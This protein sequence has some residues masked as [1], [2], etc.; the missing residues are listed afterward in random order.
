MLK[1][2]LVAV[3]ATCMSMA[4]MANNTIVEMKTSMGNIEIE[5]FNDKAPIS[6]KNF[7]DYTKAKFYNGTIFHRV[8]P[9]FMV[10]GGGMT[11]DLV[12]KP[13]RPAIQNE[14]SNGLSNKRGTLAMARTNLPHSATSQFFINVVDNNF[15]DRS[16]NNAGYAVFGQV[17]KGMHVLSLPPAFNLSHDQTLQ[18]KS[19]VAYGYKSWLINFLTNISQINFE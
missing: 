15:L 19:L 8:I 11:A 13:T 16:T 5:L 10:Q 14:S 6:A 4:V 1:K 7:E 9:G 17:T 2:S 3:A 18:L 12:E